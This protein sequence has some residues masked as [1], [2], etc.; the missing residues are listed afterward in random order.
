MFLV[1]PVKSLLTVAT[2]GMSSYSLLMLMVTLSPLEIQFLCAILNVLTAGVAVCTVVHFLP[3]ILARLDRVERLLEEEEVPAA[4]E[5]AS[6]ASE[7]LLE[8]AA[9]LAD[10]E[11]P[12]EPEESTEFADLLAS[13]APADSEKK[14][15]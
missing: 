8:L 9:S 3:Q 7:S 10:T 11:E 15:N 13:A 14:E 1:L 6:E 2:I 5:T 12:L 4:S